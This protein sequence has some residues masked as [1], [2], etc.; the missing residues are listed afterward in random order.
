MDPD[1][2]A[3]ARCVGDVDAFARDHWGRR[4]LL[5]RDAG[6]FDDLLD[7]EAVE[8]LLLTAARRPEFRLVREGATLPSG[9]VSVS[10]RV[11]G[12]TVDDVADVGRIANTSRAARR[13]C[14]RA[15]SARGCR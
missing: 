12:R 1:V 7:V 13:W 15:C 11:G 10:A 2:A 5:R 3:L 9:E 14:C 8:E 6:R 4:P